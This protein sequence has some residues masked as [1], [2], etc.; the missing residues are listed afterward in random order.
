MYLPFI[1]KYVNKYIEI[2]ECFSRRPS[3]TP[4]KIGQPSFLNLLRPWGCLRYLRSDSKKANQHW[5]NWKSSFLVPKA[6]ACF[7]TAR[8]LQQ[9]HGFAAFSEPP[10][11]GIKIRYIY[12]YLPTTKQGSLKRKERYCDLP[13]I[14]MHDVLGVAIDPLLQVLRST[15]DYSHPID[16]DEVKRPLSHFK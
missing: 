3:K 1:Y 12:H 9:K 15:Q 10:F 7:K 8:L 4:L 2:I 5:C 11:Q 16:C 6:N 13:T 14:K